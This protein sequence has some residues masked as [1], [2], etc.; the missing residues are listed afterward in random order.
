MGLGFIS[1][2]LSRAI[3]NIVDTNHNGRLDFRDLLALT[4]L[5][6]HLSSSSSSSSSSTRF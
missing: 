1:K 5:L 3:F 2:H 6:K 4:S